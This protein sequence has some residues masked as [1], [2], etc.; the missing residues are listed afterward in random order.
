MAISLGAELALAL[1]L[2]QA[3]TYAELETA[4]TEA[5]FTNYTI[6]RQVN[7]DHSGDA[8]LFVRSEFDENGSM[9]QLPAVDTLQALAT[10]LG[11]L[12]DDTPAVT[13]DAGNVTPD[14]GEVTPESDQPDSGN[15]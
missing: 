14:S 15:A 3:L 10:A 4:L 11:T 6:M 1:H 13:P 2:D 8:Q 9:G 12:N 7:P 5:G